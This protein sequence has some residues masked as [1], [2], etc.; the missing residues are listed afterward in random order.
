MLA[1]QII[2]IEKV[3][4]RSDA[5]VAATLQI[6]WVAFFSTIPALLLEPF[7]V[8]VSRTA[9]I[10]LLYAAFF[11]T[12]LGILVQN[13]AQKFTPSTHASI[14]MSLESLFGALFGILLLGELFTTRM[15]FGG[16]LIFL[17][18]L[19]TSVNLPLGWQRKFARA[20]AG[21]SS[22]R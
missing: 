22:S 20:G 13:L 14:L 9:W 12:S 1:F 19:L 2:C 4:C 15:A 17:S 21:S 5:I 11:S 16:T 3:A 8:A 6:G 7:P 10:C 18:A